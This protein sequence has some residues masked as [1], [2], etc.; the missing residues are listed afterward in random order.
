MQGARTR[1]YLF[2]KTDSK[3]KT[4]KGV[5]IT[6]QTRAV[7]TYKCRGSKKAHMPLCF[8]GAYTKIARALR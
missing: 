5:T 3:K 2:E 8:R 6:V 4:K 7:H 1:A